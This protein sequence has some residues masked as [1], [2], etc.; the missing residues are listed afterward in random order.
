MSIIE[1]LL[2]AFFIGFTVYGLIKLNKTYAVD[3]KTENKTIENRFNAYEKRENLAAE[4][5]KKNKKC[6]QMAVDDIKK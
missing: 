1:I 2:T 5:S 3:I 6:Y 4:L